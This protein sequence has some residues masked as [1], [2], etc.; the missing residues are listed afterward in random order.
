[1][2][3]NGWWYDIGTEVSLIDK[4][5]AAT[6]WIVIV[7]CVVL[8]LVMLF[9]GIS[10]TG[11]CGRG[12]FACTRGCTSFFGGTP[13]VPQPKPGPEPNV[14]ENFCELQG[15]FQYNTDKIVNTGDLLSYLQKIDQLAQKQSKKIKLNMYGFAS[16]DGEGKFN[17]GLA[18]RRAKM[19]RA[20]IVQAQAAGL[21]KNIDIGQVKGYGTTEVWGVVDRNAYKAAKS[22]GSNAWQQFAA[23]NAQLQANRRYIISTRTIPNPQ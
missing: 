10:L 17:I 13:G 11:G 21:I 19:I 23:S 2:W 9:I 22:Q 6:T 3:L 16:I 12:S 18:S 1:M 7:V 4:K 15:T 8:L 5:G 14:E 20:A